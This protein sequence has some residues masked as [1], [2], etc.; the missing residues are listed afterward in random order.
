MSAA[1][2]AAAP[3]VLT[4]EVS[5]SLTATRWIGRDLDGTTNSLN[6]PPWTL[7]A[8]A[9]LGLPPLLAKKDKTQVPTHVSCRAPPPFEQIP[10]W[11]SHSRKQLLAKPVFATS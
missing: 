2:G 1:T 9:K 7:Q 6:R 10:W 4:P 5:D 8:L 11:A 3:T